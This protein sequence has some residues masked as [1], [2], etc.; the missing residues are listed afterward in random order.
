MTGLRP[1]SAST[2]L[3]IEASEGVAQAKVESLAAGQSHRLTPD[4]KAE[5]R[6]LVTFEAKPMPS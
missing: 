2:P 5:A 6:R 4:G 1:G 3:F